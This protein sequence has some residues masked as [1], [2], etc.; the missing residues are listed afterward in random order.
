MSMYKTIIE[1]INNVKD[2]LLKV[3]NSAQRHRYLESH[4]QSLESYHNNHPN[5]E[6]N[7]T[8]LELYCNEN[9]EANECRVF[10]V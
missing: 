9:P 1:H 6:H 10:D 4:L 5:D 2:E 8:Y 7:P 3:D